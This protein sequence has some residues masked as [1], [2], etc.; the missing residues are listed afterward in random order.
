[1]A[2]ST[3]AAADRLNVPPT[4]AAVATG[5]ANNSAALITSTAEELIKRI[6]SLPQELQDEIKEM[7]IGHELPTGLIVVDRNHKLP[8]GLQ[9]DHRSRERFAKKFYKAGAVYHIRDVSAGDEDLQQARVLD[10]PFDWAYERMADWLRSLHRPHCEL[11]G[12]LRFDAVSFQETPMVGSRQETAEYFLREAEYAHR[13][14]NRQLSFHDM[15][16]HEMIEVKAIVQHTDEK[17]AV[18]Q[19]VFKYD[20][21][22]GKQSGT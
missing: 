14:V 16:H 8:L 10:L 15:A 3:T 7:L 9:L 12:V 19:V 11:L 20:E 1:M 13:S 2:Y 21:Q 6:Q 22:Y 4:A 17:N 5:D 18:E